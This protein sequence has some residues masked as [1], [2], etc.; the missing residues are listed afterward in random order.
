MKFP[1][2]L[3]LLFLTVSIVRV[4]AER[5][6][7]DPLIAASA[8]D[9]VEKLGLEM[10]KGNFKYGHE[11]M[12]PRWKRR[13]ALRAGG[14]EKLEAQLT[15]AQQQRIRI[16]LVVTAYRVGEPTAFFDVW[17]A[18]KLHPVT[19]EPVRDDTGREVVTSHWLAIVPVTMQVKVPDRQLGGKIRTLEEDTCTIAVC[20]KGT[21][22]WY[23]LTGLKPTVQDLRSLFPTLPSDEKRLG[24]PVSS[25]REIK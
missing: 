25:A 22:D 11:R 3:T 7:P 17:R 20:E 5:V 9:A 16:G 2:Y 19:G 13:L 4:G 21:D 15:S 24:L 8:K 6:I 10:M 1:Y 14:M 23:F 12:Y 18:K